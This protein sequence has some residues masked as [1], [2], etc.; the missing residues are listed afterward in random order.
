[1]MCTKVAYTTRK[2]AHFAL[3][4]IERVGGRTMWCYYCT[5]CFHYHL[6]SKRDQYYSKKQSRIVKPQ[7]R[8]KGWFASETKI[9]YT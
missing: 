7:K 4:K 5:Q 6:T 8:K 1:M 2:E 3:R 9:T